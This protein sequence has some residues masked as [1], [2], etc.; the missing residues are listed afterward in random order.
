MQQ[1]LGIAVGYSAGHV[2]QL[3]AGQR[4]PDVLAV[5]ARFIGREWEAAEVQRLLATMLATTRL[6]TLTG[7][8]GCG[9]T[10]LAPEVGTV[11]VEAN[12][13]GA[14]GDTMARR[15]VAGGTAPIA[16]SGSA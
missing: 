16:S 14:T 7:S 10:C 6:L 8:C 12:G 15:R 1:E 4:L 3:E 5:K 2:A 13:V 11:F 9:K